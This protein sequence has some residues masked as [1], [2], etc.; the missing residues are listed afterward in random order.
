VRRA[1]IVGAVLATVL[2]VGCTNAKDAQLADLHSQLLQRD[3]Q[4]TDA[5]AEV[6]RV[7]AD[8]RAAQQQSTAMGQRL[9]GLEQ[10][11][12]TYDELNRALGPDIEVGIKG[13]YLTMEVADRV[14]YGSGQAKLTSQ[15]QAALRRVASAL[16]GQF[17]GKMVRVEGH[18]DSDPI[19]KTKDLYDDNW[20]LGYERAV[21]VV[22]YLTQEAGVDAKRIHAASFGEQVPVAPNTSASNKAQNRRVAVVILPSPAR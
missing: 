11:A 20:D 17:A 18:T 14:L 5:Q 6:D 1:L 3:Q 9:S 8:L 4:L 13:G 21:A 16:N 15:G 2:A 22:R 12:S 10:R 7:S 19:Q